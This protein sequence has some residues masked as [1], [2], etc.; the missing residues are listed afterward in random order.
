MSLSTG[1][2]RVLANPQ[3]AIAERF[4]AQ[5]FVSTT[6]FVTAHP[7]AMARFARAMHESAIYNNS[8]LSET[9][10]L[11]SSFSAVPADVIERTIRSTDGEYVTARYI[12]PL[13]DFAAKYGLISHD[14]PAE[15]IIS[16]AA[17]KS[18]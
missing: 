6:D 13:I 3:G 2:L 5:V 14:F 18:P 16:P 9:I 15:E 1:K 12:Q 4:Q 17:L 10:P 7:E 11:I 8:H